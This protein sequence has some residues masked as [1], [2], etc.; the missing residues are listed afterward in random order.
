MGIIEVENLRLP[1]AIL[2]RPS[3]ES[4]PFVKKVAAQDLALL[5]R[6][7]MAEQTRRYTYIW[8]EVQLG[9]AFALGICLFLGTQKRLFPIIFSGILFLLVLFEHFGITPEL[10]Y[11]GRASDF[12]PGNAILSAQ[13]RVVA[14][15]QI[16]ASVEGIKLLLGAIVTSYLFVFRARTK[17]SKD[18]RLADLDSGR[19]RI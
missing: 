5:L 7:E 9:L 8:E 10:M 18:P 13:L 2:A 12:P 15:N 17:S 14:M 6:Y 16:Y 4:Q 11:R 3:D 1:A 19:V